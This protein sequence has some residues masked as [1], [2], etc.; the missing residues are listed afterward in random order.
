MKTLKRWILWCLIPMQKWFQRRGRRE[1]IIT[2]AIVDQ[3]VS[4]IKP[5]DILLSYEAQRLTSVF[6]KGFYDHAVIVSSRGTVI[7][8]VGD[9]WIRQN[10]VRVN[11]GGVREVPLEEWLYKKDHVAV[12]R[13]VISQELVAKAAENSLKYIGKTY[14]YEFS[15]DNEKIY[16]SELAYLCYHE[17]LPQ[18]FETMEEGREILPQM[19]IDFARFLF[20]L[21]VVMDTKGKS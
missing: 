20:Y 2:K 12:V 16:C 13:V 5:G 14:D 15:R 1:T 8:A 19:Y 11:L 7:E 18:F 3:L 6:I 17:A 9:K 4:L 21:E 10:G